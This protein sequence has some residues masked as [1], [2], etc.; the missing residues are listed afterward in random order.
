MSKLTDE[1]KRFKKKAF[2]VI[3]S[4]DKIEL[5][6]H[7]KI[8]K[9][10][11]KNHATSDENTHYETAYYNYDFERKYIMSDWYKKFFEDREEKNSLEH[12]QNWILVYQIRSLGPSFHLDWNW[13]P[14]GLRLASP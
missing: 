14:A 1:E 5:T 4:V 12:G 9:L 8:L 7:E 3:K 2:K 6:V 11:D 13:N 10:L